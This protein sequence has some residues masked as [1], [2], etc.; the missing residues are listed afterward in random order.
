MKD[1]TEDIL[2]QVVRPIQYT[3]EDYLLFTLQDIASDLLDHTRELKEHRN[4]EPGQIK[5]LVRRLMACY[6]VA[7]ELQ[8]GETTPERALETL[9]NPHRMRGVEI[10]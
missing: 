5:G 4:A 10:P 2:E 7:A 6:L 3:T 9:R 8:T 1:K